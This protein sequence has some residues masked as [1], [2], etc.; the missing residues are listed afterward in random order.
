MPNISV[1]VKTNMRASPIEGFQN[2]AIFKTGSP[3]KVDP[4]RGWLLELE[5]IN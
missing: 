4:K 5:K 1:P 2:E 3:I